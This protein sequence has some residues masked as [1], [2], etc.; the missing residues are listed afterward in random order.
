MSDKPILYYA[1][2][3]KLQWE[4][5]LVEVTSENN[6]RVWGRDLVQDKPVCIGSRHVIAQHKDYYVA[7]HAFRGARDVIEA[8]ARAVGN[9]WRAYQRTV[10]A[11]DSAIFKAAAS[12]AA[13]AQQSKRRA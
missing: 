9:A 8:E 6:G 3:R 12:K 10:K 11:A 2:I 13:P 7:L 4:L 1:I 5:Q